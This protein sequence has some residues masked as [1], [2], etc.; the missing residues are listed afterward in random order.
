[1]TINL[2]WS[3]SS[4]WLDIPWYPISSSLVPMI[5]QVLQVDLVIIS[6]FCPHYSAT[7]LLFL[8]PHLLVKLLI[9]SLHRHCQQLRQR[10]VLL[11]HGIPR[12]S[13]GRGRRGGCRARGARRG[14]GQGC[15]AALLLFDGTGW[16]PAVDRLGWWELGILGNKTC[17][18]IQRL[19]WRRR[20][21]SNH[22]DWESLYST[23]V[24]L[25]LGARNTDPPEFLIFLNL[26]WVKFFELGRGPFKRIK[27]RR[28]GCYLNILNL[29]QSWKSLE[30][31]HVQS[32]NSS[33][34]QLFVVCFFMV[35][36]VWAFQP[37][38]IDLTATT[39]AFFLLSGLKS[40]GG[41]IDPPGNW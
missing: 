40:L 4:G 13:R 24:D 9:N 39:S 28:S 31:Q 23:Y 27:T 25:I 32:E 6:P 15:G 30:I 7:V 3:I 20:P 37:G 19:G 33:H 11:S 36:Q 34:V 14:R 38:L 29:K 2:N 12:W 10:P 41:H 8:Y 22:V 1:M 17:W 26:H 35:R 18:K 5:G 21:F 16:I